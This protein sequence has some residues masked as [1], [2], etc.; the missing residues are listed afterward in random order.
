MSAKIGI[1]YAQVTIDNMY[2]GTSP[3]GKGYGGAGTDINNF[4]QTT[5][6]G[7]NRP[8]GTAPNADYVWNNCDTSK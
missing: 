5:T 4:A 6:G 1:A 3:R 8:A 2:V 7:W